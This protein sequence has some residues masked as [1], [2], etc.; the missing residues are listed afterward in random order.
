M[1]P[2]W[3]RRRVARRRTGGAPARFL[4]GDASTPPLPAACFDVVLTRHV[5][6]AMPDP[7]LDDPV[8]WGGPLRDERYLILSSR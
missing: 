3:W 4:V 1:L 2:G 7:H 5:L 8:L 6:W